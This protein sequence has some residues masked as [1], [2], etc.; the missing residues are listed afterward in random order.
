MATAVTAEVQFF[1]ELHTSGQ[2]A[3]DQQMRTNFDALIEYVLV[4]TSILVE[5][6]R[7]TLAPS[8]LEGASS[9]CSPQPGRGS[10]I[11]HTGTYRVSG[12][13]WLVASDPGLSVIFNLLR[14]VTSA[15]DVFRKC[16]EKTVDRSNAL[17][18]ALVP[19]LRLMKVLVRQ[20][21]SSLQHEMV[22]LCTQSQCFALI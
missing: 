12:P 6:S 16:P 19:Y 10:R 18:L 2:S 15:G 5:T 7:A 4:A 8:T 20:E 9:S 13:P 21:P 22:L 14:V 1:N 17:I 3:R 11:H